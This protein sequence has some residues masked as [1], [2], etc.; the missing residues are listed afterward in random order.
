DC[1]EVLKRPDH[2][3]RCSQCATDFSS[4][5]KSEKNEKSG[6]PQVMCEQCMTTTVKKALKAEHTNRLKSAFV[7]A[8]QQE[9]EIEQRM[10]R[11]NSPLT[12]PP[13]QCMPP[14]P[15]PPPPPPPPPK[16]EKPPPQVP[17]MPKIS[18]PKFFSSHM[19]N[20][21]AAAQAHQQ[22]LRSI[23]HSP[24]QPLPAH[25]LSPFNPL[26]YPYQLAALAAAGAGK[27]SAV[28]LQR[29]TAELQRQ[30]AEL[31][32]QYLLD[33]IPPSTFTH[34]LKGWKH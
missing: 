16:V 31:Q 17:Q 20:A 9:Q 10:A 12:P 32:R 15:A 22:L 33:M 24:H 1:Q 6:E 2:P 8:L 34:G 27:S 11:S 3:F 28:E 21:A 4:V 29:Q 7:K 13:A 14:S 30:A 5:W 25:L 23:P 19:L 18:D 26:L